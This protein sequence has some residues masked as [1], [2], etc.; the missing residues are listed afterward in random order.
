VIKLFVLLFAI[1]LTG[2]KLA[3]P[4]CQIIDL[5]D[6]ACHIFVLTDENGNK[7]EVKMTGKEAKQFLMTGM[8]AKPCK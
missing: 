4:A 7:Q 2:C 1:G 5:A 6:N 8:K 3:K